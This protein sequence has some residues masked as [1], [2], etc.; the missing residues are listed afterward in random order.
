MPSE[1]EGQA[2]AHPL[3]ADVN[4][5]LRAHADPRYGENHLERALDRFAIS[6]EQSAE[7]AG[8]LGGLAW[9]HCRQ[10]QYA[11]AR[12]TAQRALAIDAG[13]GLA[14]QVLG[15]MA[16]KSGRLEEAERCL[17]EAIH[18][19]PLGSAFARIYRSHV[20]RKLLQRLPGCSF[21]LSLGALADQLS[22][23]VLYP[24]AAEALPFA[25][26]PALLG[27]TLHGF[28]REETG[29]RDEALSVYL[30]ALG[31]YPGSDHLMVL[32]AQVY[33]QQNRPDEALTWASRAVA[34]N[35]LNEAARYQLV[36]V[37]EMVNQPE[38]VLEH[39]EALLL[40]NPDDPHLH[41]HLGNVYF[42]QDRMEDALTHYQLAMQLSTDNHWRGL[43]AQSI[44]NIYFEYFQNTEAAKVAYQMAISL[45][46]AEP[47]NYIQLGLAYY[48]DEDYAN[49][50]AVYQN[51]I[52]L[53]RG[54]AK[55]FSNLGYLRWLQEDIASAVRY[56][57]ESIA[58][59]GDYEIPRNNLGVIYLDTLGNPQMA[60]A[61]LEEALTINQD[62]A[63]AHYNLGRAYSLLGQ[64]LKAAACFHQARN[65]NQYTNELDN[66]E[67]DARIT[68]LFESTSS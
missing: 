46:P 10:G 23:V 51:A 55:L 35:P 13:E 28:F 21:R 56:Y 18:R 59:D 6:L 31:R 33:V 41:C 4:A 25:C 39:Y 43:L 47:Q 15:Y 14:N 44:G 2:T 64:T 40:L 34:R 30:R 63:L 50:E 52:R 58:L 7:T 29:R 53:S 42:Q 60:I 3:R 26:W 49:A 19:N 45:N 27:A 62:Y 17:S 12:Q 65:I 57:E 32:I 1:L 37:Y 38:Q 61:L 22:A 9:I 36:K 20:R 68:D 8:V 11:R 48:G 16:L 66:D 24:F 5:V 67:L 54:N